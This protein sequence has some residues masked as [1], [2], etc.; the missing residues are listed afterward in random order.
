GVVQLLLCVEQVEERTRSKI[1]ILHAVEVA[2]ARHQFLAAGKTL[3]QTTERTDLLPRLLKSRPYRKSCIV[4][5][6]SRTFQRMAC[7][8]QPGARRTAVVDRRRY[9]DANPILDFPL[10]TSAVIIEII[11]SICLQ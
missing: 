5:R 9:V 2:R 7:S 3:A 6:C 10:S 8:P 4:A 1:H 11:G